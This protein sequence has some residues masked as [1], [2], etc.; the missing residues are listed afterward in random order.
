MRWLRGV[1]ALAVLAV[2]ILGAPFALSAWGRPPAGLASLARPEDGSVLLA[3]LTIAGWLAWGAF[4]LATLAEAVRLGG[5]RHRAL[6]LP[7]LGGL[8]ELSAGLLVAVLA[9]APGVAAT[10][11]PEV[12][13]S[14]TAEAVPPPAAD[15][16]VAATSADPA[17][18]HLVEPGD[19]LWTLSARVLGDGGRWRELVAA[20]PEVLRDPTE[21][22]APGTRLVLPTSARRQPRAVTVRRGDTLS[23]LALEHLGAAERWPQIA[24]ANH[25]LITDPDHIEVGWRLVIP[26]AATLSRR[27]ERDR[28]R[29]EAPSDAEPADPPA[30]GDAPDRSGNPAS[31]PTEAGLPTHVAAQTGAP[32]TGA[33]QTGASQTGAPQTSQG[34]AAAEAEPT[35]DPALALPLL[36]SLGTLAAAAIIGV[37]ETRRFLRL[38]ERPV[39]RRLVPPEQ[40]AARLRAA[41][42]IHRQPDR[43]A[44]LD[45]ALRAVGRHC[46]DTGVPLP[47]LERVLVGRVRIRLEWAHPAGPPPAGFTGDAEHWEA[48]VAAP[49]DAADHP[50]PYPGVVSLGST[51][52]D[53]LVLVDAERS[54]VLGVATGDAELGRSAL[55]AMGVELACAPWSDAVR[56]VAVGSD[57]G[58]IALAGGDRVEVLPGVPEAVEYLR[59]L[60][61]GRRSALRDEPLALL[62]VDPDRAD[63]V[64]PVVFCMLDDVPAAL[65]GEL[66][67]LLAGPA[68]GLVALLA[69][70][71]TEDARWEVGGDV[72]QPR[73]RLAGVGE[74]LRV[75]A[76]GESTR[77]GV[78][79][80]FRAADSEATAIAPWWRDPGTAGDNVLALP[81]RAPRE[82]DPVDIVRLVPATDHPHVLLIG[83]AELRGAAGAEP[84]RSRQQL[85][86]LCAWLLEHPGSTATAMAAGLMVAESTRRSNLSRLRAWLG[87]APD[88]AAYLP[89]AYSGRVLLHPG[90]TSDWHQLQVLLAPG[91][92]G[93]G[94]GT[95]VAALE[96]IR[97]APLAD[98]APTQ[99]HWAEELRTDVSCAL[100][101]VGLVLTGRALERGDIDLARWAASRALVVAPEDEQLL[102]ARIRTE[103]RASNTTE[104]ARLVNQVTRQARVLGVDLL[105]ETVALCQQ[106]LEGRLRAR[107]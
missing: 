97:G 45:A 61:G 37:V 69:T 79:R 25:E 98:A 84:V 7:L 1:G 102:C 44:A 95:L 12:P 27:V 35:A 103:L 5:R 31:T 96:L 13:P 68:A 54:R 71:P 73:G 66:D 24:E 21:R 62:R 85:V 34:A 33:P 15:P 82:G 20:N 17:D 72:D 59:G 28:A 58:L 91:V 60:L 36:G 67:D 30:P 22:L 53:D 9:L 88:G 39:G 86:E 90:V 81:Q 42:A 77:V 51:A 10:G 6:R 83:P 18:V 70:R 38:R 93:V 48:S 52:D 106:A 19:D 92:N 104:V 76:I 49:P 47:D 56:L 74:P 32:Q 3:V 11:G 14:A 107:A 80:L 94:D 99:W 46:H 23:G 4:L 100:R 65:A 26:G 16:V 55:A 43:L 41:L 75:H 29:E 8:Q 2:V 57:A 87:E 78:S 50:C 101:D 63:A 89:D 40:S 64:A 105:P